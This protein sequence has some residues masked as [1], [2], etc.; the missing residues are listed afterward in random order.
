[1]PRVQAKVLVT[2]DNNGSVCAVGERTIAY[3]IPSTYVLKIISFRH[4]V[5]VVQ[6]Y[7]N[8]VIL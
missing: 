1:M 4:A 6:D 3:L 7:D 2:S 8:I 5:R